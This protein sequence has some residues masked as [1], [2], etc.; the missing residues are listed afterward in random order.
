MRFAGEYGLAL[1]IFAGGRLRSRGGAAGYGAAARSR[2]ALHEDDPAQN[3]TNPGT[4]EA[5][6]RA[7]QAW[8]EADDAAAAL[9]EFEAALKLS[10]GAPALEFGR[11]SALEKLPG[12]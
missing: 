5:C 1:R 6:G 10:P 4:A 9:E 2:K 8:L 12:R 3:W 11:A 7:A